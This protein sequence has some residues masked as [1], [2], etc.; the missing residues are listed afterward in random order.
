MINGLNMSFDINK[1]ITVNLSFS[2]ERF[3]IDYES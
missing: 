1:R 3:V 2:F